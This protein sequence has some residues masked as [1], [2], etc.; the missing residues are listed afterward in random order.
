MGEETGIAVEVGP[1][2]GTVELPGPDDDG[3]GVTDFSCT[4]IGPGRELLPGDDAVDARWVTRE[5]L[6]RLDTSP[7]LVDTLTGW[8]VWDRRS[9]FSAR[10]SLGGESGS[11][12]VGRIQKG[13]GGQE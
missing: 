9:P 8:G 12:Q 5:E 6:E 11:D 2:V 7:G 13:G 10:P 1:V 4:P 3:Y